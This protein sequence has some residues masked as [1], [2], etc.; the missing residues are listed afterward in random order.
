[1]SQTSPLSPASDRVKAGAAF[2]LGLA[3]ILGALAFQFIG[4]LYPCE[5]CLT[6]RWPYYIGLPLLAL[7]L[8]V[9]RKLPTPFRVGLMGVVA[10]LFAWGAWVG[11]YHAGVEWGWWPGPQSCTGVGDDAVSLDMLSDMSDVRIV[12]CDAIQWEMAGISL[13]GFN[14]LISA[15]IVVMLVLAIIGQLRRKA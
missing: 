13:A 4:G 14:A 8:I 15:A 12:P 2:V 6:Q 5:L 3:A 9:W 1:M 11:G 10:G 7:A